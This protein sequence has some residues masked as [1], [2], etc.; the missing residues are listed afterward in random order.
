MTLINKKYN[1]PR[2]A[3]HAL[4]DWIMNFQTLDMKLPVLWFRTVMVFCEHYGQHLTEEQRSDIKYMV[5]KKH[6]HYI[7]SKEIVRRLAN[8][9]QSLNV[10]MIND[11]MMIRDH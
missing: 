9:G 10:T 3:L 5:K 1:L 7:L 2:S 8:R 4:F 11:S 6:K